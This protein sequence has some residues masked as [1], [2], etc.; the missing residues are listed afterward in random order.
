MESEFQSL[1]RELSELR[2]QAQAREWQQA[3][4][5]GSYQ[6][7]VQGTNARLA[8]LEARL[9]SLILLMLGKSPL[10]KSLGTPSGDAAASPS[11]PPLPPAQ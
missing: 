9:D 1:R 4:M 6:A 11:F 3:E 8:G 2:A 7:Y 10:A 5:K